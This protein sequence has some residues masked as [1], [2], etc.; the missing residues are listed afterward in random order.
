MVAWTPPFGDGEK[1]SSL[2]SESVGWD[3][4]PIG[5]MI[6]GVELPLPYRE[7]HEGGFYLVR[8]RGHWQSKGFVL[9]Q[10]WL[11]PLRVAPCKG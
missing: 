9:E 10:S 5:M 6:R 4:T 2:G 7:G 1:E 3:L 11:L 8:W